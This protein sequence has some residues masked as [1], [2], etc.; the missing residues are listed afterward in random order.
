MEKEQVIGTFSLATG[1]QIPT[2]LSNEGL[3]D[4]SQGVIRDNVLDLRDNSNT[5][6]YVDLDKTNQQTVTENINYDKGDNLTNN[7][8]N[9]VISDNNQNTD[10][11]V[12]K[13]GN[14]DASTDFDDYSHAALFS[15]LLGENGLSIFDDTELKRDLSPVEFV[16]QFKN[17]TNAYTNSIIKQELDSLGT[18]K[19]HVEAIYHN[20]IDPE[21][22]NP[23]I[24]LQRYADMDI[25]NPDLTENDIIDSVK[26]MYKLQG[27]AD[28][29]ISDLVEMDKEK[30][31]L[32]AKAGKSKE[33]HNAYI[34]NAFENIKRN[35]EFE[36]LQAKQQQERESAAFV[37]KLRSVDNLY[38]QKITDSHRAAIFDN[39]YKRDQLVNIQGEDNKQEQVL[40]T[41]YELLMYNVVNNPE[42]FIKLNYLLLNDLNYTDNNGNDNSININ[43]KII[44]AL[45]KGKGKVVN[46]VRNINPNGEHQHQQQ[47]QSDDVIMG[48]YSLTP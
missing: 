42:K 48:T 1:D 36:D 40:M 11:P 47:K 41:K 14:Q 33:V 32:V 10:T 19:A 25:N 5:I 18:I 23:L 26:S 27:V 43:K 30:G 38:N 15:K 20:N 4:S 45:E 35:K 8:D 7:Q 29:L 6:P 31:I 46:N 13:P 34:G 17:K 21:V 12:N 16:E 39:I 24:S 28:D 3:I 44:D 9:P 37:E 2:D 22:V